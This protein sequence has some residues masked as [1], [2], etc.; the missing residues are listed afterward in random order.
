[1]A[2]ARF[3]GIWKSREQKILDRAKWVLADVHDTKDLIDYD[4]SDSDFEGD[5]EYRNDESW[6]EKFLGL[7]NDI[8]N[9]IN[10]LL[11]KYVSSGAE[12]RKSG[13]NPHELVITIPDGRSQKFKKIDWYE[14][15][16]NLLQ[17]SNGK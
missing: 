15:D 12:A 9:A 16:I 11:H 1:M 2:R 17:R 5:L 3:S 7:E 4:Q 13:K 10:G 8:I 14:D 6:R